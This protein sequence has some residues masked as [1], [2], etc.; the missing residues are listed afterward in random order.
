MYIPSIGKFKESAIV[1]ELDSLD[2]YV[3]ELEVKLE[4]FVKEF[5]LNDMGVLG[6]K[7]VSEEVK[8]LRDKYSYPKM[9]T[10]SVDYEEQKVLLTS[11]IEEVSGALSL[12]SKVESNRE[13]FD[14][15][16]NH[17]KQVRE[18]IPVYNMAEKFVYDNVQNIPYESEYFN[19]YIEK[20]YA[21]QLPMLMFHQKLDKKDEFSDAR[22][23]LR[24]ITV[25]LTPEQYPRDVVLSFWNRHLPLESDVKV[26]KMIMDKVDKAIP[27]ERLLEEPKR[28]FFVPKKFID[29]KRERN[30]RDLARVYKEFKHKSKDVK[31]FKRDAD[32]YTKKADVLEKRQLIEEDLRGYVSAVN[33]RLGTSIE[34]KVE[35]E[36]K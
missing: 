21:N 15:V 26:L 14:L 17:H 25:Q 22:I 31:T 9:G 30:I 33:D 4:P 12:V 20:T 11:Q 23:L 28:S 27:S 2:K 24:T 1:S 34:V 13:A 5:D 35:L 29:R 36:D 8:Q 16:L 10:S 3:K 6:N 18:F 32:A 19:L 7:P